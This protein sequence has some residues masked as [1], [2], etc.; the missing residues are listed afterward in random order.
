[1]QMTQ[2]WRADRYTYLPQIGVEIFVT[3][4]LLELGAVWRWWRVSLG[5][6]A[7]VVLMTLSLGA[8]VQTAYW[9]DSVSLWQHTVTCTTG[10]AFADN[11]LGCALINQQK[12]GEAIPYLR[13]ALELEPDVAEPHVNLGI[14]L[15]AQGNQNDAVHEFERALQINPNYAYAQCSLG[16]ALA[17]QGRTDDAIQHFKSALQ[18]SPDYGEAH[19]NLGLALAS[20]GKWEEA[21]HHY[22]LALHLQLNRMDAEYLTAVALAGQKKWAEASGLYQ[23]VLQQ[24]PEFAEAQYNSGIALASQ[25]KFTEAIQHFQKASILAAAQGNPALAESVRM[26]LKSCL[27]ARPQ[28]SGPESN[29]P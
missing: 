13:E 22:E 25:G 29:L 7:A 11:L 23:Q 2:N 10:N 18:L 6:V 3:W 14:A 28:T 26:Q 1:M 21:S 19:Y 15:V 16:D 8:H 20:E 17:A 12:S 24:K 4:G 27:A 9:K 5:I